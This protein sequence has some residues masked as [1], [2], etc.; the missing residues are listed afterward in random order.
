LPSR[1]EPPQ[2]R[3]GSRID[4]QPQHLPVP[5]GDLRP[6]RRARITAV[7]VRVWRRRGP[8]LVAALGLL[9]AVAGVL[10][11]LSRPPLSVYI[12]GDTVHVAGQ[13]LSHPPDNGGLTTG[14]LYDG[15][16]TLLLVTRPDGAIV[17]S[18]VTYLD[19]QKATGICDFGP[20]TATD[21]SERCQLR[22]GGEV[23]TCDDVLRFDQPG[24]WRRHC[25]DGQWLTVA[26]PPGTVAIPM[27]FPLGR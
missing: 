5:I 13:V 26:V 8:E 7:P 22:I 27:P 24:T 20:P 14:R 18:A 4:R 1:L 9:L 19:G 12:Q 21:V 23:V 11:V 15:S 6:V 2:A 17:A 10:V 3:L 25:S 16:A